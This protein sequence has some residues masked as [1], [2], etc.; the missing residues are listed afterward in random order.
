MSTFRRGFTL[1]ELLVVIA[2]IGVLIALLLPAVQAAREAARRIKCTNNMKQLGLAMHNYHDLH[3]VLPPGRIAAANCPRDIFVGC[4]NTPW[5]VMMLPQFEQQPLA[6]AF[7]FDLGTEG[8]LAPIP[9]LGFFVNS[10][11]TGTKL[12]LFQ[13]PS[14]SN[15]HYEINPLIGGGYFNGVT[16]SKGN[17]G[18]NWGNTYWGQDQPN[19]SG[20]LTDPFNGLP[21]RF[22]P[23]P[24]GHDGRIGFAS[25]RDGLS[26]TALMSEVLQGSLYDQRGVLWSTAMGASSYTSRF[27]PNSFNDYYQ[28]EN[29]SDRLTS[30]E[31]CD[32]QPR[33]KLPCQPA[34]A[35]PDQRRRAFAGAKSRHNGGVNILLGDGSVRFIKD[36]ISP[37]IWLALNSMDNGEVID[38]NSY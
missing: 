20:V 36:T 38:G 3:N 35:G 16:M 14:D 15:E 12:D 19:P 25:I 26:T 11:V 7:N 5:F 24:F 13:C 31:V 9:I 10:T 23:S 32:N 34:A 28:V 21:A 6:N 2:I 29:G 22:L 1:I 30:P 17:Y 37:T 18:V 33:R 4:Q 27:P 8:P